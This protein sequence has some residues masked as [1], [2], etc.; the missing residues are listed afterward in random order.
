M[1]QSPVWTAFI[2]YV[3]PQVPYGTLF[4]TFQRE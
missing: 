4:E 3:R 2:S 1:A